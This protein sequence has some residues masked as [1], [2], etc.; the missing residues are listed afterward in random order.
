MKKSILLLAFGALFT[1]VNAQ[2][3]PGAG[4]LFVGGA[5]GFNT[6]KIGDA[7]ASKI[8]V[9]PSVGYFLNDGMAVGGNL[10]F[11]QQ[12]AEGLKGGTKFGVGAF[13]RKYWSLADNFY[14]IAEAGGSFTS[15]TE[16]YADVP[17]VEA[18]KAATGFGIGV[19]PG[20][21]FYPGKKWGVE[22]AMGNILSF[23]S[24]KQ[25]PDADAST[26]INVGFDTM[27]PSISVVYFLK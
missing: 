17:G 5:L 4:K 1:S 12:M 22:F 24:A 16:A 21:G 26:T 11:E 7:S 20:L 3:K 25:D 15:E 2:D 27:V 13:L 19:N 9:S 18:P 8:N 6:T 10:M 14:F 23:S